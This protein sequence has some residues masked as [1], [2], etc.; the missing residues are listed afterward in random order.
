MGRGWSGVERRD[1]PGYC[2]PPDFSVSQGE[3]G[4]RGEIGPQGI[5]GQK[6]SASH[7]GP[8]LG[9]SA[10]AGTAGPRISVLSRLHCEASPARASVCWSVKWSQGP[11]WYRRQDRG[12]SDHAGPGTWQG[13]AAPA[14]GWGVTSTFHFRVT[15]VRGGQWGSRVLQGGR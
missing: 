14:G 4:P 12:H 13:E 10:A 11:P 1:P 2:S 7:T 8:S 3:P 5:M 6:V 15:R 9:P